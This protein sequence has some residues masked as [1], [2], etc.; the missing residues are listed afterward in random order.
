[1]EA[2]KERKKIVEDE[3]ETLNALLPVEEGG[4]I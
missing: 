4:F 3:T 2:F 1:L